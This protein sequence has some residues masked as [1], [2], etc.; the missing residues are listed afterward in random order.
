[1]S[2]ATN[3]AAVAS[4]QWKEVAVR[5]SVLCVSSLQTDTLPGFVQSDQTPAPLY[6]R[7]GSGPPS[8]LAGHG[9]TSSICKIQSYIYNSAHFIIRVV[10]SIVTVE[11]NIFSGYP[12]IYKKLKYIG[13]NEH[14]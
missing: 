14:V 10:C 1:M 4:V 7:H 13:V 6:S 8:S 3:V 12:L 2:D 9:T 5:C 11:N